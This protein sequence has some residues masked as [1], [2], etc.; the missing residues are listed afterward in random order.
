ME[1]ARHAARARSGRLLL[2]MPEELHEELSRASEREGISLNAFIT[3]T[4][5]AAVG[6][7]TGSRPAAQAPGKRAAA[8]AP[9]SRRRSLELL[10][11]ANLVIVAAVGVLAA[12]LLVRAAG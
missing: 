8:S 1:A 4:L 7:Q 11:V 9:P 2:R 10:L 6:L 5:A 12:V 3:S